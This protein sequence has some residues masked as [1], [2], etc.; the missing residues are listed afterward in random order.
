MSVIINYNKYDT[1]S[2]VP[3]IIKDQMIKELERE[4]RVKMLKYPLILSILIGVALSTEIGMSGVLVGL[5]FFVMS[6][7]YMHKMTI[8]GIN[9]TTGERDEEK[10][11]MAV[12]DLLKR[13][14][15]QL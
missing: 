2:Q 3:R 1:A 10:I 14:R 13:K 15:E 12:D 11:N 4:R 8:P 5:L 7:S 9:P 6:F